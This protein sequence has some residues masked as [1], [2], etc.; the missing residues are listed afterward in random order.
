M[1]FRLKRRSCCV[2][3]ITRKNI[4][5][6]QAERVKMTEK[7]YTPGEIVAL[8]VQDPAQRHKDRVMYLM[9]PKKAK[10]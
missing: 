4:A 3:P 5:R 1:K 8:F 6:V 7:P 10:S 2:T 9:N